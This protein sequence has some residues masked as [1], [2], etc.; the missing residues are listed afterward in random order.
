MI[1]DCEEKLGNEG[2][3]LFRYSGTENKARIM[4][5]GENEGKIDQMARD[6]KDV[7]LTEIRAQV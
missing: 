7:A 6:L 5:E 2:R 3:V 1:K 4:I